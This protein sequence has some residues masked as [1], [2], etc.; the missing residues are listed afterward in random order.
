MPS[1]QK[2]IKALQ[3]WWRLT[4][5]GQWSRLL[6]WLMWAGHEALAEEGWTL[7]SNSRSP[8]SFTAFLPFVIALPITACHILPIFPGSAQTQ[9]PMKPSWTHLSSCWFCLHL[10]SLM[11]DLSYSA[12]SFVHVHMAS[13][14]SLR[15]RSVHQALF[16]NL[17]LM[18][19]NPHS[20][21]Q[22]V[23]P[24]SQMGN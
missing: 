5:E 10:S 14:S 11:K 13:H 4:V 1:V 16:W 22:R 8:P 3:R 20:N 12:P 6:K 21:L 24:I 2:H 18:I 9:S 17:M 7:E 19:S 23:G 15:V